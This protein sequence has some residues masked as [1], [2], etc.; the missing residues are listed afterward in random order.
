MRLP[1]VFSELDT[2]L[3]TAFAPV[4]TPG[5]C[6]SLAAW[7][8]GTVV[9]RSAC[10]TLVTT[11]LVET[12]A[13]G[14]EHAVRARLRE[15]V[16]NA[17][18][19]AAPGHAQVDPE[20]CFAPLLSWILQH[21]QG[22]E[23]ALALDATAHTDRLAAVVV[24][25]LLY[26]RAIPV[27][28]HI[29]PGQQPGA[30]MDPALRLLDT[31]A[32][33]LRTAGITR[34]TLAA[35]RG[36]WSPRLADHLHALGWIGLL[37]VQ[38]N[39]SV[40]R[41]PNQRV[42]ACRLVSAPG[43]A[44]VGRAT[45]HKHRAQRRIQTVMVVWLLGHA[46]PW[47]IFTTVPP[48]EAGLLWYGLRMW[49]ETGFRDLKRMGW[50]WER[51]RRTDPLRV[52]RHWLVLA[53]ATVWTLLSGEPDTASDAALALPLPSATSRRAPSVSAFQ[54]GRFRLLGVLTGARAR[55]PARLRPAPWPDHA[56]LPLA[57]TR[58]SDPPYL[59]R[60]AL[61]PSVYLPL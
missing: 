34:V 45:V 32:P 39:V 59:P 17:D 42:A 33:A 27:A 56:T 51:T 10:E 22:H 43:H 52:S 11:A 50:Q 61:L 7:V 2:E 3:S 31:L 23:V 49:I 38:A 20:R 4:L 29:L 5:H 13:L 58:C 48:T 60:S 41:G 15:F 40:W 57:I 24:S 53:V 28:W 30:F 46:E 47:V 19:H 25:V 21:W 18:E 6:R 12:F 14:G 9:A 37:R 35:D 16:R 26:G 54:R 36:L 8:A 55:T 1:P 44:W